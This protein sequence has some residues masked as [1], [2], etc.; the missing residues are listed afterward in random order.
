MNIICFTNHCQDNFYFNEVRDWREG[1][2]AKK[3]SACIRRWREV[4]LLTTGEP[5]SRVNHHGMVINMNEALVRTLDQVREVLARTQK[6][7]LRPVADEMGA[8]H[9]SSKHSTD[10]T[11]GV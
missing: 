10:L 4:R 7:Q 2:D 1:R 9:G 5:A 8:A 3:K 6:L 11:T